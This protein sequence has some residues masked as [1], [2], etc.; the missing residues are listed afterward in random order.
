MT[1]NNLANEERYQAILSI[2]EEETIR[3]HK[4]LINHLE[5]KGI[6]V[7]QS[8]ISRDLRALHIEKDKETQSYQAS[9]QTRYENHIR[10]LKALN[11]DHPPTLYGNVS[12]CVLHVQPGQASTYAYHLQQAFPDLIL[13]ITIEINRLIL[14]VNMDLDTNAFVEVLEEINGKN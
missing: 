6:R 14:L 1:Q 10:A 2:L 5:A 13:H 9:K 4:D 8:T 11:A 3:T 7:E 12:P